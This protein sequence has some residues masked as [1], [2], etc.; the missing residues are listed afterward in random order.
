MPRGKKKSVAESVVAEVTTENAATTKKVG[1]PRTATKAKTATASKKT[2]TKTASPKTKTTANKT[3]TKPTKKTATNKTTTPSPKRTTK[4]STNNTGDQV[5]LQGKGEY[6]FSEITELC[7][8]AYR[9][10]TKKQIKSIKVYIKAE[11]NNLK[12]YYVVNDSIN[13]SVDL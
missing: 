5:I 3:A 13:G 9:N 7:K 10:G 6:T 12:A 11:K 1:K 2:A 4:K 8:K